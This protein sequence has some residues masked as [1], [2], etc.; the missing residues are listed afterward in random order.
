MPETLLSIFYATI[1]GIESEDKQ[2]GDDGKIRRRDLIDWDCLKIRRLIDRF[3]AEFVNLGFFA[4][5]KENSMNNSSNKSI[6]TKK[7]SSNLNLSNLN[8]KPAPYHVPARPQPPQQNLP[9]KPNN[10]PQPQ[11][12]IAPSQ[13]NFQFKSASNIT[14]SSISKSNFSNPPVIHISSQSSSQ[15]S[16]QASQRTFSQG[17]ENFNFNFKLKSLNF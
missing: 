15:A 10:L 5:N 3:D 11:Q 14:A 12:T 9:Q 1:E 17:I 2:I 13:R 16:S 6:N 4:T 7:S 8:K